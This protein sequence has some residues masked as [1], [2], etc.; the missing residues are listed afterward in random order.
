MDSDAED[1]TNACHVYWKFRLS[2]G[3]V[4]IQKVAD[5]FFLLVESHIFVRD[6]WR[7]LYSFPSDDLTEQNIIVKKVIRMNDQMPEFSGHKLK[8]LV[9]EWTCSCTVAMPCKPRS[10]RV[11]ECC[12]LDL[13]NLQ[14]Q[15]TEEAWVVQT[16]TPVNTVLRTLRITK[17]HEYLTSRWAGDEVGRWGKD[18]RM[19]VTGLV[20]VIIHFV[21]YF[22]LFLLPT[23]NL[24]AATYRTWAFYA[25]KVFQNSRT[26]FE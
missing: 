2:Q 15:S 10:H 6:Y 21:M 23:H 14:I 25:I 22:L 13:W 3:K 26:I 1:A 17:G 8:D 7:L 12:N 11:D 18:T 20:S 4:P 24:D 5:A 16:K 19:P 9:V